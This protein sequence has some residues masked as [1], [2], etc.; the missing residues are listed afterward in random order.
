MW[1]WFFDECTEYIIMDEELYDG[2]YYLLIH[3]SVYK[4]QG[5]CEKHGI[6]PNGPTLW[7]RCKENYYIKNG[8]IKSLTHGNK[9]H[10][11]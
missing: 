7:K 1:F 5:R 3:F 2:P 10:N 6:I 11:K 4:Y 9:T 8:L